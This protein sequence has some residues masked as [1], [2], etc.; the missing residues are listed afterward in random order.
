[1]TTYRVYATAFHL[2]HI[3]VSAANEQDA[4]DIG[5][6][7][8]FA[9]GGTDTPYLGNESAYRHLEAAEVFH[10]VRPL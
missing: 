10:S 4:E 2:V 3:D 5:M 6:L 8:I 9:E 1:M 7:S